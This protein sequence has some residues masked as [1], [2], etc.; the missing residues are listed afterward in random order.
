MVKPGKPDYPDLV[1]RDQY[2]IAV[3]RCRELGIDPRRH[4]T[5]PDHLDL[6][7]PGTRGLWVD[8]IDWVDR[9]HRQVYEV[10]DWNHGS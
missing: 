9:F 4:A 7:L 5:I 8:G 6:K 1:I 3:D 2:W 10:K